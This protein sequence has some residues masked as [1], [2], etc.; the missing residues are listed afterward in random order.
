MN[1]L[2]LF[3]FLKPTLRLD[4]LIK[5]AVMDVWNYKYFIVSMCV[6]S[7]FCDIVILFVFK[8]SLLLNRF[9]S[10]SLMILKISVVG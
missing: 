7:V 9:L 2:V 8:D 1:L 10:L 5:E 3:N 6:S 4:L